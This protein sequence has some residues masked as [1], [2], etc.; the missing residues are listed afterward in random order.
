MRKKTKQKTVLLFG[1]NFY[2]SK[3]KKKKKHSQIG[4]PQS[5]RNKKI[6]LDINAVYNLINSNSV[7]GQQTPKSM[8]IKQLPSVESKNNFSSPVAYQ[9]LLVKK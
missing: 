6:L 7:A 1:R 9:Y 4:V 5:I 8:I 2:F 3:S